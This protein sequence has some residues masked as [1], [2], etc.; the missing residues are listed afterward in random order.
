MNKFGVRIE[1]ISSLIDGQTSDETLR[2]L[3]EVWESHPIPDALKLDNDSAFG[4]NLNHRGCIGKVSIALLNLG[5]TP[6]YVAQRSP[7]SNGSV[8]GFNSIFSKKYCNKLHFS[9]E[10]ELSVKI[11]QFNLEYEKYTDLVANNPSIE[12]PV[13]LTGEE[14]E[15]ALISKKVQGFKANRIIFLRIVRRTGEKGVISNFKKF[16]F[17]H[18]LSDKII[19]SLSV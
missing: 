17:V 9:D 13:Y 15:K 10:E 5:V 16:P 7:W 12:S 11:K 2:I 18:G 3:K 8:E 19:F 14:E 6:I 1:A 4:A